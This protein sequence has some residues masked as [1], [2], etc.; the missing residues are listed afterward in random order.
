MLDS[1]DIS[2]EVSSD[3]VSSFFAFIFLLLSSSDIMVK[4]RHLYNIISL[5]AEKVEKVT[6]SLFIL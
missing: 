4:F 2:Y 1:K 5:D 6:F 3:V